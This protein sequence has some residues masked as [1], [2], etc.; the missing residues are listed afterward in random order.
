MGRSW[1]NVSSTLTQPAK[2]SSDG[3]RFCPGDLRVYGLTSWAGTVYE[4]FPVVQLL[5]ASE[6]W[7]CLAAFHIWERRQ[8]VLLPPSRLSYE[9]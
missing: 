8:V 7:S 9:L 1:I 6:F 4:E 5:N 2:L 3:K